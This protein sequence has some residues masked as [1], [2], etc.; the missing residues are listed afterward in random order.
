MSRTIKHTWKG[1]ARR[2]LPPV[3][4]ARVSLAP[5]LFGRV[6]RARV[7]LAPGLFG[8]VWRARV[9]LAPGLFGRISLA[10]VSLALALLPAARASAQVRAGVPYEG[11]RAQLATVGLEIREVRVPEDL[12][13]PVR[14]ALG[15]SGGQD[16]SALLAIRVLGSRDEALAW[17]RDRA[18]LASARGLHERAE[19][20]WADTE[21]GS[22]SLVIRVRA[23][24]V[25]DVRA[26]AAGLDAGAI[27]SAVVR[28]ID[29]APEGAPE[30]F[31]VAP[32]ELPSDAAVGTSHP[33]Q[34]PAELVAA[35]VVAEGEAYAR[36]TPNGWV[37]TRTGPGHFGARI[38]GV[39]ALLRPTR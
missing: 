1:K 3:W 27:A 10:L 8:R 13:A 38:V 22:A 35:R 6:W 32:P 28:A 29:M 30:A 36:R 25:V 37:V 34:V 9:S 18:R 5:G 23:N 15:Q 24:V 4:R 31:A 14:M 33:V 12:A 26:V 7:S 11:L 21:R 17:A 39:D 20:S 2:A 16:A 19:G